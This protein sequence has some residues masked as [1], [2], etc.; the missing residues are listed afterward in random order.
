MGQ[1]MP[2][3]CCEILPGDT[4]FGKSQALLRWNTLLR[5]VMHHVTARLHYWYVPNRIVWDNWEEF[6]VNADSGFT[7]PTVS[8]TSAA[9][10]AAGN[11]K[12]GDALGIYNGGTKNV[13]ALPVRAYNK[14]WN[15]FYRDQDIDAAV[16]EDSN[17]IQLIRFGKDYFTRART[18]IQQGAVETLSVAADIPITEV[19]DKLK[20]QRFREHKSQFGSRYHDYLAALGLKVPDSRLDRPE[21]LGMGHV[22]S[23]FADVVSTSYTATNPVGSYTGHG[24]GALTARLRKRHFVEHGFLLGL[25]SIRPRHVRG[26]WAERFWLKSTWDHFFQPELQHQTQQEIWQRENSIR[27][28]TAVPSVFGYTARFEEYR[29]QLDMHASTMS[30]PANRPWTFA[31][32]PGSHQPLDSAYIECDPGLDPFVDQGSSRDEVFAFL[33][34]GVRA[35]RI[36]PRRSK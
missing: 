4:W 15:E 30:T 3:M 8:W 12:I 13:N 7:I 21:Y 24:L 10:P 29:R 22:V 18:E 35:R 6:I 32:F 20:V 25:L 9:T 2:V 5:P 16:A 26:W 28:G 36:V 31:Q 33:H 19:R 27:Y 17:D 1:L 23:S 34:H 11:M 14:I